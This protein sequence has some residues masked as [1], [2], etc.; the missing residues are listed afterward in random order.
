[1]IVVDRTKKNYFF[2]RMCEVGN[3]PRTARLETTLV[4]ARLETSL[5]GSRLETNL[6]LH[7]ARLASGLS[8]NISGPSPHVLVGLFCNFYKF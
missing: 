6:A 7:A 1:M 2:P 8:P 3:Q 4:G 5:V